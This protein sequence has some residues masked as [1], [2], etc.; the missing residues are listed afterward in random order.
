MLTFG[1]TLTERRSASF[2]SSYPASWLKIDYRISA[3]IECRVFFPVRQSSSS[4]YPM[5]VMPSASS[6]SR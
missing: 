2:V 1:R 4:P 5:T 6:S 3:T